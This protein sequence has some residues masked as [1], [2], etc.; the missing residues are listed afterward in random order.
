MLS[1]SIEFSLQVQTTQLHLPHPPTT[2][3]KGRAWWKTSKGSNR[4]I[5]SSE[6]WESFTFSLLYV[7]CCKNMPREVISTT[8]FL[9]QKLVFP[10]F[11]PHFQHTFKRYFPSLNLQTIIIY[12]LVSIMNINSSLSLTSLYI[13]ISPRQTLDFKP[14][15][16]E[17]YVRLSM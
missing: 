5:C 13:Y 15:Y 17:K 16:K 9:L 10:L 7:C 4:D 14:L 6:C 1:L 8:S 12:L 2:I 11:E 3:S